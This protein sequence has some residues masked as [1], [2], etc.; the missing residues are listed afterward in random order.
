[1]TQPK[2][3][4]KRYSDDDLGKALNAVRRGLSVRS[5]SREFRIPQ[6]TIRDK[7]KGKYTTGAKPGGISILSV[8]IERKIVEWIEYSARSGLPITFKRLRISVGQYICEAFE[9][10]NAV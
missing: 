3:L 6:Q 5:V 7:I 8:E 10:E 2:P 9:A 4:R 1:M